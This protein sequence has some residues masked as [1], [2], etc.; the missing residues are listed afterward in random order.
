MIG[1][2]PV[3]VLHPLL[4]S[5]ANLGPLT[6]APADSYDNDPN[7]LSATQEEKQSL[8]STSDSKNPKNQKNSKNEGN[9]AADNLSLGDDSDQPTEP[10]AKPENFELAPIANSPINGPGNG[11]SLPAEPPL[12]A[13]PAGDLAPPPP[14]ANP[15]NANLSAPP[16]PPPP[17]VSPPP[18]VAVP[19]PAP[20]PPPSG[21]V[22]NAFTIADV[23]PATATLH[24]VGYHYQPT[25][26]LVRIEMVTKGHPRYD[27]FQEK[28]KA[29]QPEIIVRFLN[30]SLR[31][32]IRRDIDASEFTSPVAYVRMRPA[33]EQQHVD[34]VITLRD[35]V[36]PKLFAK[37]G[38]V[39]LTFAIPD[40]YFGPSAIGDSPIARASFLPG[41]DLFPEIDPG[42]DAP[43][44][45][46]V[47]KQVPIDPGTEAFQG[48]PETAAT[49][50][51]PAPVPQTTALDQEG[52]PPS[53]DSPPA[54]IAP[55]TNTAAPVANNL[56][57]SG[58]TFN[59]ETS[60]TNS[61]NNTANPNFNNANGDGNAGGN[62]GGNT[63][64]NNFETNDT[65]ETGDG[66]GDE[67]EAPLDDDSIKDFD[68]GEGNGGDTID[69]FD[70][71]RK[72]SPTVWAGVPLKIT[73][74]SAMAVAQESFGAN[75]NQGSGAATDGGGDF[76][77][78]GDA[79]FTDPP[80]NS[81]QAN[82][83]ANAA[84]FPNS[85]VAPNAAPNA[86]PNV[87][88]N[89]AP[90]VSTNAAPNAAANIVP[91]V[92]PPQNFS[93]PPQAE[94]PLG[95]SPDLTGQEQVG[96]ESASPPLGSGG[97]KPI[98]M[99]FR[100]APLSEVMRVLTE[101]SGINFVLPLD[102]GT[103]MVN[104]S[105]NNVPFNDALK[106]ILDSQSLGMVTLAP[107]L[108]RVDSA[109]NITRA[110]E[111]AEKRRKAEMKLAP[112][113]ILVY[114]LNYSKAPDAA[115]VLGEMLAAPALEDPRIKVQTD[116]R[117]NS[118]IVNAPVTEL[119]MIKAL[120]QR[121]DL[122]TP[123]VKISSR[124]VEVFKSAADSL[125]ITWGGPFN[126]D[127]G[128]GLGF[129]NLVFPNSVLSRYSVD[130]GG[131][132]DKSLNF[133]SRIG[134]INNSM[135]FDLALSMEESMGTGEVLQS[136]NIIV[137][138]N[139]RAEI[140]AGQSD[141]FRV[142]LANGAG[143]LRE[144]QYN[145]TMTVTPHIT[146][147]GAV[148]MN[149]TIASDTPRASSGGDAVAARNNRTITTT[150]LRRSGET[151]V[152]GGIYNTTHNKAVSGVPF[153]SRLPIVGAL[154]RSTSENDEKR[155]LLVMVTPTVVNIGKNSQGGGIATAAGSNEFS[156]NSSAETNAPVNSG[157]NNNASG[158]VNGG[159][160]E[161]GFTNANFGQSNDNQGN[162]NQSNG[163]N[164]GSN[165]S[166]PQN[167]GNTDEE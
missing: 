52:L 83:A 53:F 57:P 30:T 78:G 156:G 138:D 127:Q 34:V 108:V 130:N 90:N 153:L 145:L 106:A 133:K 110:A 160:G 92:A 103:R 135:A 19:T 159:S 59:G 136:G 94:P 51:D 81:G 32:K 102:V 29:Q 26:S 115:R 147:D 16:A 112:T 20:P 113:K 142:T 27:L 80:A 111:E 101:E 124:I 82:P 143:D 121:I 148:Q 48:V 60:P 161:A 3:L 140:V 56:A 96:A 24:W 89:L 150:L 35:Q 85:N 109:D 77:E 39:M 73:P 122:E 12:D 25:A 114:R 5:C 165:N 1:M 69:K 139:Q 128:R 166:E 41:K 64:S 149:I 9:Q 40:H 36:K 23:D 74:W 11:Q 144:V 4:W 18:V 86:A 151:A 55:P 117:S 21:T 37:N 134:S 163:G 154:F 118:V 75:L 71:R 100:G 119:N 152:I 120:L 132:T 131:L 97:G 42:S 47:E 157:L 46:I 95:G 158:N 164:Q 66:N 45:Y 87:S 14:P 7:D 72:V 68:D 13:A 67:E 141:F 49:P 2:I 126:L 98:K 116:D 137:E 58:N 43:Q 79:G 123:Q 99:D 162:T 28:N 6:E 88:T 91:A 44:S 8:K 129:G 54:N 93:P 105:L 107:Q 63:G 70:V 10:E 33:P 65:G 155:E 38:N 125:G 22:T 31:P 50:V 62:T 84:P 76:G 146:A 104:V 167:Q 15:L 17:A 61:G